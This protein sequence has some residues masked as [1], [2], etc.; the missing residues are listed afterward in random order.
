MV[1]VTDRIA[2]GYRR[3]PSEQVTIQV[4]SFP[5]AVLKVLMLDS[6]LSVLGSD[7]LML[8]S[9]WPMLGSNLSL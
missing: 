3:C 6:D 1:A 7:L 5:C 2:R 8:G 9:V 4:L